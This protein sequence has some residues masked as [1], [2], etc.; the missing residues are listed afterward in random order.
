M[1]QPTAR[2]DKLGQQV[3]AVK[4]D[5]IIKSIDKHDLSQNVCDVCVRVAYR[6]A[7]DARKSC[8][9]GEWD[10]TRHYIVWLSATN[11]ALLQLDA[12]LERENEN[13]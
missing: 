2:L 6:H 1:E 13:S 4:T 11:M 12:P 5:R 3:F 9:S 8:N 7:G 10:C